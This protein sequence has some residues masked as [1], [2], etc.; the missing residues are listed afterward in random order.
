MQTQQL[1]F[2][3]L[4]IKQS[5][6]KETNFQIEQGMENRFFKVFL[7]KYSLAELLLFKI[8]ESLRI[9]QIIEIIKIKK[10]AIKAPI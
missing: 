8:F 3:L 7:L 10:V 1:S 5:S 6:V 2:L 4:H 9:Y